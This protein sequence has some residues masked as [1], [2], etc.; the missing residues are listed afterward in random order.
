MKRTGGRYDYSYNAQTAVDETVQIV[1]AAELSNNSA[2]NDRLPV[3]LAAV[4]ANLGDDA[5]QVLADAGFR[6]ESV[7]E[8]LNQMCSPCYRP[9]LAGREFRCAR[10]CAQ[11]SSRTES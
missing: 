9:P 3:L 11:L 4:K 10:L 7:S 1:V 8:R 6:S 2:D 5:K